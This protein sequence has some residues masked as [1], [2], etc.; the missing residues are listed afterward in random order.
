MIWG[1]KDGLGHPE[2]HDC[3]CC[4]KHVNPK[5][6]WA[7]HVINGGS[8]VLHPADEHLYQ[9][10]GGDMGCHFVG[11]ECRKQFGEFTFKWQ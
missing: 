9:P 1:K 2:G 3:A 7:V 6:M 4:G 11:S 8:D 5:R 10:D